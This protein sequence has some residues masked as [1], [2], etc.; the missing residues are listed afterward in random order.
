MFLIGVFEEALKGLI[1]QT[2]K[3]LRSD[4]IRFLLYEISLFSGL[5]KAFKGLLKR[6]K[7]FKRPCKRPLKGLLK[8]FEKPLKDLFYPN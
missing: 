2:T 7:A 1:R 8:A 3:Q 4:R 5:S 6:L